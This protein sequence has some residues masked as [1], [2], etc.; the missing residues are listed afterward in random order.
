MSVNKSLT[1]I[2]TELTVNTA[3][4]KL[5]VSSENY[6][7]FTLSSIKFGYYLISIRFHINTKQCTINDLQ[8]T[9]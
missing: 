5:S 1:F 7:T 9:Q 4:S 2:D 8:T 6:Y 3:T